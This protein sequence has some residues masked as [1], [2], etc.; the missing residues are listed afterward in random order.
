M[1]ILQQYRPSGKKLFFTVMEWKFTDYIAAKMQRKFI[2]ETDIWECF[3][4]AMFRQTFRGI[5]SCDTLHLQ[6]VHVYVSL[7]PYCEYTE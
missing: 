3:S 2:K 1:Y 7:S 4:L 6:K 5:Q